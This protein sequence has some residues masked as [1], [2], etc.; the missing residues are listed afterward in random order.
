MADTKIVLSGNMHLPLIATTASFRDWRTLWDFNKVLKKKRKN[1]LILFHG[2]KNNTGDTVVVRKPKKKETSGATKKHH[3]FKT[4]A[5]NVFLRLRVLD[6]NLDPPKDA[7]YTLHVGSKKYPKSGEGEFEDGG[8]INVEVSKQSQN[9]R[10]VVRYKQ[11]KAPDESKD[12][13]DGDADAAKEP[14]VIEVVYDLEVGALN[15][16][17]EEAPDAKCLSGV[18]QRLNNLGFDAG[19]VDG[20]DGPNTQ[21]AVKRFQTLFKLTVD[22]LAYAKTQKA[23]YDFHD[24]PG[25]APGREP[26]KPPPRPKS[27]HP[28]KPDTSGTGG[29]KAKPKPAPPPPPRPRTSHGPV[30]GKSGTGGGKD[31]PKPPPPPRPRRPPGPVPKKPGTGGG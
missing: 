12:A 14:D 11:P 24:Q 30:P 2:D 26:P 10:L 17:Q 27:P 25:K 6:E 16:I 13:P 19:V 7:T 18:Q 22:G 31:R 21:G 20:I 15:P 29:G 1:A 8:M 9:A 4:V 5:D 28:A 3:P 23:L